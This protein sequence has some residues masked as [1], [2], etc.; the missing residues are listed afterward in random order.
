[1]YGTYVMICNSEYDLPLRCLVKGMV[2][3]M[4]QKKANGKHSLV[5]NDKA[6]NLAG[7]RDQNDALLVFPGHL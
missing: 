4:M 5:E 1:M 6:Y 7:F 2:G 3:V